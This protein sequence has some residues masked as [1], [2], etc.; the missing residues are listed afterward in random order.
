MARRKKIETEYILQ[1]NNKIYKF[2]SKIAV[3]KFINEFNIREYILDEVK[4]S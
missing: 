1:I 3:D 4:I 2:T